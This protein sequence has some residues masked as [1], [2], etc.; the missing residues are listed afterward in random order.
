[1]YTGMLHLHSALRYVV[2]VLL[3]VAIVKSLIGW[4]SGKQFDKTDDRIGLFLMAAA[5]LQLVIGLVLYFVS[6][7]LEVALTDM[8]AAMK[9]AN[10]RFWAVEHITLMIVAIIAV[11]VGRVSTK[12]AATDLKKHQR[13]AIFYAIAFGLIMNAIPWADR[14]FF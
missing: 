6:P 1:M 4:F 8:G 13:S 10:L 14:G 2:L 11:T 7:L 5:H 3:V 9:D 12:K